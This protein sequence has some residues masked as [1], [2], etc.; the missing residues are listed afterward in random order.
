[1]CHIEE[2]L[3]NSQR[4]GMNTCLGWWL[5]RRSKASSGYLGP[6]EL[7]S[8]HSMPPCPS[9]L[10]HLFPSPHPTY[11]RLENV[12]FHLSIVQGRAG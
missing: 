9:F 11:Q 1:M 12:I 7:N 6:S 8:H 4:L 2:A 10:S 3:T 5:R